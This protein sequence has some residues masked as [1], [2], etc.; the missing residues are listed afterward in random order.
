MAVVLR[1]DWMDGRIPTQGEP[2]TGGVYP[3]FGFAYSPSLP[4]T[5]YAGADFT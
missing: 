2:S 1:Y 3:G 5:G 4:D